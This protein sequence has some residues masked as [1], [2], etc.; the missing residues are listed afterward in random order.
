MKLFKIPEIPKFFMRNPSFFFHFFFTKMKHC[1]YF[2]H[3]SEF[4]RTDI[5]VY[6]FYNDTLNKTK[7]RP[8]YQ[9]KASLF[10]S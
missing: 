4:I 1:Y 7:R 6:V 3:R 10:N 8:L 5:Y 9:Y 2:S